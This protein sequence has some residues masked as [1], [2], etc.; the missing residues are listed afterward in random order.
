MSSIEPRLLLPGLRIIKTA[1]FYEEMHVYVKLQLSKN[2]G[3][4]TLLHFPV[5]VQQK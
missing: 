1:I 3:F 4:D 5:A 2:C